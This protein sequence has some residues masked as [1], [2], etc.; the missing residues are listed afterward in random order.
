MAKKKGYVFLIILAALLWSLDALVRRQL[1]IIPAPALVTIE[2]CLRLLV[3][4]PL[5]N[6]FLPEYR[7]M[8]KRDWWI[9]FG[10]G[11]V[12]GMIGVTMFTAA[13]GKVDD[14]SYSVVALLQ[15]TQPIFAVLLAVLILK[16]KLTRRFMIWGSIALLA[17]YFLAFPDYS[18]TFLGSRAELIAAGLSLGAAVAWGSGTVLSKLMLSKLSYAATAFLRFVITAITALLLSVFTG[19]T[20]SLTAITSQQWGLLLFIAVFGGVAS[21]MLYY[22]GLQHTQAKV[23]TFAELTYPLT[24]ALIGFGFLGERLTSSQIIAALVLVGAILAITLDPDEA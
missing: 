14:I 7:K 23:S 24:A 16:E 12:S 15:Q 8:T 9:M 18:P 2:Y 11:G 4:L 22:K 20:Y 21:F 13:L 19:Q 6:R 17:T 5:A 1:S 3:L 10:V